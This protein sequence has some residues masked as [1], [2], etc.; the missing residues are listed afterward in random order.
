MSVTRAVFPLPALIMS[1]VLA[2]RLVTIIGI[3]HQDLADSLSSRTHGAWIQ[4]MESCRWAYDVFL[5]TVHGAG[6]QQLAHASGL[7]SLLRLLGLKVDTN[8]GGRW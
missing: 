7:T 2:A 1:R 4:E 6:H 5:Q 8:F 3:P